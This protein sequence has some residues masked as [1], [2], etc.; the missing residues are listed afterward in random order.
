MKKLFGTDGVRG[1]A[2][3]FLTSELCYK[4]AKA[5]A[6]SLFYE[7]KEKP[8]VL[9][10]MDTRLSG[11]MLQAAIAAG[12]CSVG[13]DVHLLGVVP[14]P[15]V[16]WLVKESEAQLGVMISAS[17]NPA[18]DNGLK[19]FQENGEKLSDQQEMAIEA[20]METLEHVKKIPGDKVGVIA[21]RDDYLA[22]YESFL[23]Q[24]A[25][26]NLS[27]MKIALDM[28]HG[29]TYSIA[30][31]VFKS[32]GVE[33]VDLFNEPNGLNINQNCGSTHISALTKTVQDGNFDLG[34]AFDGDG[35]RC[36]A[37][38]PDGT[39]IDGDQ[40]MYLCMK[41][42][43]YLQDCPAV[44]ATVMSNMALENAFKDMGKDFIRTKVGDRYVLEA[45]NEKGLKLGGE[46]SG[47]TIIMEHQIT[48]DGILTAI[49]LL[50]ALKISGQSADELLAPIQL[51]P[52]L[53]KNVMVSPDKKATWNKNQGIQA[54]IEAAKSEFGST[55]RVLVRASGTEPKI[56]VMGEGQDSQLVERLVD[57][58][59]ET[60][61]AE[62]C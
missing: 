19:F 31:R 56:R 57:E 14:T 23:V 2:N 12:F 1:E 9:I 26:V 44:V 55:G 10:G 37:V 25:Q 33:T 59:V 24:S 27:G 3:T 49:Q 41:F 13:Y 35:D 60:V 62:L 52:Q 21:K 61:K 45:L 53:L 22:K 50:C 36:L 43:P 48:G 15:A 30:P 20:M 16:A 5:C 4:L 46:Q 18:H 7:S 40:I 39:L 34:I 11:T 6:L 58:L 28:A 42:L 8:F 32:L 51:F 38:R 29:A 17:H 47:H 54:K